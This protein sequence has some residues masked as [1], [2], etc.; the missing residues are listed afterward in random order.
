MFT[1]DNLFPKYEGAKISILNRE[2]TLSKKEYL[3]GE[4]ATLTDGELVIY[5]TPYFDKVLLP[6]EVEGIDFK[7]YD[8]EIFTFEEYKEKVRELTEKILKEC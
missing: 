6:V 1:M 4:L 8:K 3:S 2:F 5:A 7:A